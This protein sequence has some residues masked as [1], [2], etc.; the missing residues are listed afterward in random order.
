MHLNI[1][2]WVILG[3]HLVSCDRPVQSQPT[4]FSSKYDY[5][6]HTYSLFAMVDRAGKV[7]AAALLDNGSYRTADL[8][9]GD[10]GFYLRLSKDGAPEL[11]DM[12]MKCESPVVLWDGNVLSKISDEELMR[13]I[14]K[15]IDSTGSHK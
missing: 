8:F 12:P 5:L 2:L 6:N 9:R 4:W 3:G 11:H 7:E 13:G 1:S 10:D 14:Q 15:L